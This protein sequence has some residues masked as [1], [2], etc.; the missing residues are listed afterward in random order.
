[1]S[2]DGLPTGENTAP[3]HRDVADPH[4]ATEE[5][6][7]RQQRPGGANPPRDD[8]GPN[9]GRHDGGP[10]PKPRNVE[11]EGPRKGVRK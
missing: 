2:R 6:Y 7:D 1:M 8:I 5:H 9:S 4:P 10:R 3:P 11:D